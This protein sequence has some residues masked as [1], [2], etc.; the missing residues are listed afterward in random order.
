MYDKYDIIRLFDSTQYW[1]YHD[2][3]GEFLWTQ[4]PQRITIIQKNTL[5]KITN[6]TD[7]YKPDTINVYSIGR[8]QEMVELE[9]MRKEEELCC[10]TWD[11]RKLE[12]EMLEVRL[13]EYPS[14]QF[15]EKRTLTKRGDSG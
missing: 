15:L 12:E 3:F 14:R 10:I 11:L 1:E 2:F 6:M 9:F 5:N 7:I 4:T 13:V 8:E